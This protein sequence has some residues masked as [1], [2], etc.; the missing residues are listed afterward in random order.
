[1]D[2]RW[3]DLRATLHL[4]GADSVETLLTQITA[5]PKQIHPTALEVLKFIEVY[6]KNRRS[7]M[8]LS[9]VSDI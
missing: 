1:M 2:G 3:D 4:N 9:L 5:L 7:S 6:L 8:H